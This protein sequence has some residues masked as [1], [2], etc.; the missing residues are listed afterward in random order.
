MS[1]S[2]RTWTEHQLENIVGNLLR[3]GVMLAAVVVFGG[4]ALYLIRHGAI[5]PDYRVFHGEPA[6]SAQRLRHCYRCPGLA[7]SGDHPTRTPA[8]GG[9]PDRARGVLCLC[10]RTAARS[11]LRHRHL[12]RFRCA[13]VQPPWGISVKVTRE[14]RTCAS[15]STWRLS[16]VCPPCRYASASSVRSGHA[17]NAA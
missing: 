15:A 8:A 7:E 12:G 11:H 1:S 6:D 2:K 17:Q 3:V 10:L 4:G 16:S 14:A 9:H 5:S 13:P